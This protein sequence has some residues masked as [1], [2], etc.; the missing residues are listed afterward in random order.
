[1]L[2]TGESTS[3]SVPTVKPF[4]DSPGSE[5]PGYSEGRNADEESE[6]T[7]EQESVP[8]LGDLVY[9]TGVVSPPPGKEKH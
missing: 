7:T 5:A 8:D 6:K 3:C 2:G 4:V 9:Q 1:M